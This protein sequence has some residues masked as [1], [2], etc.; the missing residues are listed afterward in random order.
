[1]RCPVGEAEL[2]GR[3]NGESEGEAVGI[4]VANRSRYGSSGAGVY[5]DPFG[6][7]CDLSAE[8]SRDPD[9]VGETE[10]EG[11]GYEEEDSHFEQEK[12]PRGAVERE[13]NWGMW[14]TIHGP[15]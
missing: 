11:N 5:R 13:G 2:A 8:R 1:M 9:G 3:M 14:G 10:D 12:A 4:E 6:E 7:S 15:P